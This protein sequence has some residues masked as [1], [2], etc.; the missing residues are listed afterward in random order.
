MASESGKEASSDGICSWVRHQP[1]CAAGRPA[2]TAQMCRSQARLA[3]S[4]SITKPCFCRGGMMGGSGASFNGS[5]LAARGLIVVTINVRLNVHRRS[6]ANHTTPCTACHAVS[7]G[8]AG[9]LGS[10]CAPRCNHRG[11]KWNRKRRNEWS[12]RPDH[13]G[14]FLLT[15]N[16]VHGW[17]LTN[18][19]AFAWTKSQLA[20]VQ[21]YIEYFGGD[22]NKVTLFGQSAGGLSVCSIVVSPVARGLFRRAIIQSGSCVGACKFGFSSSSAF[23]KQSYLE[24]KML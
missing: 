13:R 17:S 2:R 12:A 4:S 5:R 6:F 11:S 16:S 22:A 24:P 8:P 14:A 19:N 1:H 9:F 23:S 21:R 18:T 7:A 20:W 3:S 15:E 10:F